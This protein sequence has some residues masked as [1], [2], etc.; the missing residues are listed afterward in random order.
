MQVNNL[1]ALENASPQSTC[2]SS[3]NMFY[4][5]SFQAKSFEE[6][7][8]E[9]VVHLPARASKTR[10]EFSEVRGDGLPLSEQEVVGLDVGVDD[11]RAVKLVHHVQDAGSEVEHQR[12]GH[13]LLAAALV[14]VDGIL[15]GEK[16]VPLYDWPTD[17]KNCTA[18]RK[19]I[20]GGG[21][22]SMKTSM[23][24]HPDLRAEK[25]SSGKKPPFKW[26]TTF[27]LP[28]CNVKCYQE[29]KLNCRQRA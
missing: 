19:E 5:F 28:I 27:L 20:G 22:K 29:L 17:R 26:K 7:N 11:A 4:S 16:S 1:I 23:K 24:K 25:D 15:E 6:Q 8:W 18:S 3:H 9:R 12:L 14:Q 21:S 13:H 10:S 2:R